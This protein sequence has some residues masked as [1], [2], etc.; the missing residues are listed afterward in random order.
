M[1]DVE[2]MYRQHDAYEVC[3]LRGVLFQGCV[4]SGEFNFRAVPSVSPSMCLLTTIVRSTRIFQ[5]LRRKPQSAKSE[6]DAA[7][8]KSW[9]RRYRSPMCTPVCR[10]KRLS[11]L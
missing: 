4:V 10:G 5:A 2:A 7:A 3:H 11:Q 8:W 1:E 9:L 6:E